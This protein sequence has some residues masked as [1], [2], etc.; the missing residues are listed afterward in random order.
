MVNLHK[1]SIKRDGPNIAEYIGAKVTKLMVTKEAQMSLLR[2][3]CHQAC[4][5][6][7]VHDM[8]LKVTNLLDLSAQTL[9]TLNASMSHSDRAISI[10]TDSCIDGWR[11]T[12]KSARHAEETVCGQP[13]ISALR[14]SSICTF[15]C[16]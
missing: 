2:K 13:N 7:H 6:E 16:Y 11:R 8:L 1:C 9:T 4:S 3:V 10:D 5:A 15:D 14:T 12:F